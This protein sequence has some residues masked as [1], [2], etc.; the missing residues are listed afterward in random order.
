MKGFLTEA[1]SRQSYPA[2][3][4][5]LGLTEANVRMM[6]TRLRRR[7][8]EIVPLEVSETLGSEEDADDELRQ[9]LRALRGE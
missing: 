4:E 5:E 2:V 7:Y 8:G 1:V 3:G 6:V 9:L